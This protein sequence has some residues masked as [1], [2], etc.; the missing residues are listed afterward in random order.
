MGDIGVALVGP[1]V[2]VR[3][4]QAALQLAGDGRVLARLTRRCWLTRPV[5]ARAARPL[6][7]RGCP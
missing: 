5:F 4:G 7:W 6:S 2:R 1:D 3:R